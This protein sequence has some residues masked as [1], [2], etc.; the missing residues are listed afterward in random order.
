MLFKK[1]KLVFTEDLKEDIT[2]DS[3]VPY[4]TAKALVIS[5]ADG[6]FVGSVKVLKISD[7]IQK[8]SAYVY[9]GVHKQEAHKLYTWPTNLGDHKAWGESKRIFLA[10][11]VMNFPISISAVENKNHIT[12]KFINPEE[13]KATPP[14]IQASPEF[15]DYLD[16]QEAYFFLRKDKN[17]PV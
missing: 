3:N 10:Q 8:T 6:H 12:W 7:L 1:G 13:F 11:H 2:P 17:E 5:E 14:G 4:F 16:H 15:Q 9:D